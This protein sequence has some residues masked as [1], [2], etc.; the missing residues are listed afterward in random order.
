MNPSDF[1]LGT[2]E[3]RAAA[4]ARKASIVNSTYHCGVCFLTGFQVVDSDRPDFVPTLGME[5]HGGI[6]IWRCPK[7]IDPSKEAAVQALIRSGL[8]EGSCPRDLM[9][10]NGNGS[11]RG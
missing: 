4:R 3:S 10:R 7:H 1:P 6:W 5:K 2:I 11:H 9:R 8:L